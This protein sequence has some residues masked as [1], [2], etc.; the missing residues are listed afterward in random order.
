MGKQIQISD[1]AFIADGTKIVGKVKIG[2]KTSIWYN[3]VI[4]SDYANT[5]VIIGSNSNIQDGSVV[6]LDATD[7][8]IVGDNVTIGHNCIIHGCTIDD[9]ALIG[10]GAILLNGSK[11]GK[12]AII[13]AGSVVKQ[14]CVVEPN[15][16]YAGIPAKKIRDLS[17]EQALSGRHIADDY[18]ELA[19]MHST[20]KFEKYE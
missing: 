2:D 6:H 12:N 1:T 20:D 5:E 7:S 3:C 19:V 16:L 17:A 11:I 9:G 8:A 4:R 14:G 18:M 10:M 15:T 13:A